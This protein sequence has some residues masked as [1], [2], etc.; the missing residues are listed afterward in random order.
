M[1]YPIIM[2]VNYLFYIKDF[3]WGIMSDKRY[4]I[5][6]EG[7]GNDSPME[8]LDCTLEQCIHILYLKFSEIIIL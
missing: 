2:H 5:F 4:G 7:T 6:R 3:S 1:F 8:H